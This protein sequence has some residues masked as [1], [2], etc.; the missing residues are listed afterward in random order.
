MMYSYTSMTR[1]NGTSSISVCR[2]LDLG[3]DPNPRL[4]PEREDPLALQSDLDLDLHGG[5]RESQPCLG[6]LC[7]DLHISCE[8]DDR[9][10]R[11]RPWLVAGR[12]KGGVGPCP[13]RIDDERGPEWENAA[14][15]WRL[16][17]LCALGLPCSSGRRSEPCRPRLEED[18]LQ[19]VPWA[20]LLGQ[21]GDLAALAEI[22]QR[23]PWRELAVSLSPLPVPASR[24][25]V[26]LRSFALL[27]A[28]VFE[29]IPGGAAASGVTQTAA[30]IG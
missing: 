12:L 21:Q 15:R 25:G 5:L 23:K 7:L 16:V 14:R 10:A 8:L 29:A 27:S 17:D 6:G 18:P 24:P 19:K 11:D 22:G 3:I 26:G 4:G 28:P 13:A 9:L 30:L 1:S 20:V 2:C